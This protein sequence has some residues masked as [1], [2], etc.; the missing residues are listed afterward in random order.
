MTGGISNKKVDN[1]EN[2][3]I[4]K[5]QHLEAEL[6]TCE[7]KLLVAAQKLDVVRFVFRRISEIYRYL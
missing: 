4:R 1:V 3:L 6:E 2:F 5:V 7:D